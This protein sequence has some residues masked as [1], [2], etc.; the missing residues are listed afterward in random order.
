M[1][2]F[3]GGVCRFVFICCMLARLWGVLCLVAGRCWRHVPAIGRKV[4]LAV[5]MSKTVFAGRM[6][7]ASEN[8]LL[9]RWWNSRD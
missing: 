7:V 8:D 9:E 4:R 1:S 2:H 6:G 5:K 3:L